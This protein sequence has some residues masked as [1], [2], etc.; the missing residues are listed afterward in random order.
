MREKDYTNLTPTTM[1]KSRIRISIVYLDITCGHNLWKIWLYN[2]D[3]EAREKLSRAQ[4]FAL[5]GIT[6]PKH[7]SYEALEAVSELI[8]EEWNGLVKIKHDDSMDI[9]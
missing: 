1:K 6:L 5:F 3:M 7:Y 8:Q 4:F 2:D 9:S